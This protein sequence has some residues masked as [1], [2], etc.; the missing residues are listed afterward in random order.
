MKRHEAPLRH[1]DLPVVQSWNTRARAYPGNHALVGAMA[2]GTLRA[3]NI[4]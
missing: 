4:P 1:P 2:D 3:V